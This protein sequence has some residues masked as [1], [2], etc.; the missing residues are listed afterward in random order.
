MVADIEQAR[1]T[2]ARLKSACTEL[3][4]SA[5]TFERWQRNGTICIDGRPAAA[6]PEPVHKLT[7]EEREQLVARLRAQDQRKNE[8]LATLAHELRNPLA[9]IRNGLQWMKLAGNDSAAVEQ[10]RAM[11]ERQVGHMVRLIDDLLDLSRVSS[12]MHS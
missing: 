2:G 6:R 10:A 8:F 12:R 9:P 7:E 11:M 1:K 5:R 4:V 3:G